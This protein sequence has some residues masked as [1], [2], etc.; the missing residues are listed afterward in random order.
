[1]TGTLRLV[2]A[3]LIGHGKRG[4]QLG[5]DSP[6]MVVR[7]LTCLD[8]R[9][10]VELEFA[11]RPEYGLVHPLFTRVDGGLVARGG[12][13]FAVLSSPVDVQVDDSSV[14]ATWTVEASETLAFALQCSQSWEVQPE[15][16]SQ[17]RIVDR[18]EDT[19]DA[20]RSWS[21]LHQHYEGPWR[22]LVHHS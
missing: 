17:Q 4:H 11:P 3:L 19:I 9:V 1:P 20:W 7:Q 15:A 22:E 13:H 10:D 18:L 5:I 8:G 16:W 12:A 6:S 21:A 2:D 14:R